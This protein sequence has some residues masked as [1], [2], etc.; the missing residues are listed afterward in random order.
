[1]RTALLFLVVVAGCRRSAEPPQRARDDAGLLRKYDPSTSIPVEQKRVEDLPPELQETVRAQAAQ[2]AAGLEGARVELR[3]AWAHGG[4]ASFAPGAGARLVAVDVDI[5]LSTGGGFDPDDL[6]LVDADRGES[7]GSDPEIHRLTG[8]GQVAD[9][10][11]P[12]FTD[13][14]RIRMLLVY[15]APRATTRIKLSYWGRDVGGA[16]V[17]APSG[18]NVPVESL[19]VVSHAT[20]GAA[21]LAGYLRHRVLIEAKSWSR[22]ARPDW[23]TLAYRLTGKDRFADGDHFIEVDQAGSPIDAPLA[24]RPLVVPVR[25]FV[26]EFWLVEGGTELAFNQFGRRT[27]LPASA[28]VLSPAAEKALA[29]AQPDLDASHYHPDLESE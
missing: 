4:P 1:M 24:K 18:P 7:F 9:W 26:I 16:A 20:A 23:F 5:Q 21:P 11:D 25:R 28:L 22:I 27:P 10:D 8:D 12:V 3:R 19:R 15:A 6:E 17:I 13:P 2:Q 14:D 29:R